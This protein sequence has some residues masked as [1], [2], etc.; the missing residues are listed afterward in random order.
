MG[1]KTREFFSQ[2]GPFIAM[3]RV[4][5]VARCCSCCF[6]FYRTLKRTE[7]TEA[8]VLLPSAPACGLVKYSVPPKGQSLPIFAIW[9]GV[10]GQY[11][12]ETVL[13]SRAVLVAFLWLILLSKSVKG[14]HG[15][16]RFRMVKGV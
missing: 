5:V 3:M 12:K 6:V 13:S 7:T 16:S 1:R 15:R 10:G 9:E 2:R 14:K 8:S 11:M 4:F